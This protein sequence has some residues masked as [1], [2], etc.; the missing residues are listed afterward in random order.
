[1]STSERPVPAAGQ[2][3]GYHGDEWEITERVNAFGSWPCRRIV[4]G[5]RGELTSEGLKRLYD[6]VRHATPEAKPLQGRSD[7]LPGQPTTSVGSGSAAKAHVHVW[8][9]LVGEFQRCCSKCL[10]QSAYE[11]SD[12]ACPF[13]CCE[14]HRGYAKDSIAAGYRPADFHGPAIVPDLKALKAD[15]L[16]GTWKVG[17]DWAAK[18]APKPQRAT[19]ASLMASLRAEEGVPPP[20]MC[21]ECG[22]P[23][24]VKGKRR[25][26]LADKLW[27]WECHAQADYHTATVMAR[28]GESKPWPVKD[29]PWRPSVDPLFD[30]PEWNEFGSRKP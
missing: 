6:F 16:N 5:A 28:S 24:A 23:G 13:V 10:K 26:D 14:A 3:W 21:Q 19:Y 8:Q 11:C 12:P 18:P 1:M 29:E 27:C 9:Q 15:L 25:A 20:K 17:V 7:G 2:V 30:I 22:K 4:D